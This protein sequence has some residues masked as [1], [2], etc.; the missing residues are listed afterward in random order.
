MTD[1]WNLKKKKN[2]IQPVS[3]PNFIDFCSFIANFRY[4]ADLNQCKCD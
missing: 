3:L 2:P 4:G 1:N